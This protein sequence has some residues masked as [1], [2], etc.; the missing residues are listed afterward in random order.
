M[1]MVLKRLLKHVEF[2]FKV[3]KFRNRKI[4]ET[5]KKWNISIKQFKHGLY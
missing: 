1:E 2:I 3:V 5:N 4:L